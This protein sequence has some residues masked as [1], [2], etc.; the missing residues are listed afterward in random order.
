MVGYPMTEQELLVW[1]GLRLTVV[2]IFTGVLLM[3]KQWARGMEEHRRHVNEK[4]RE[5]G[6]SDLEHPL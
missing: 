1:I 5:L 3:I 6:L 2:L 4:L